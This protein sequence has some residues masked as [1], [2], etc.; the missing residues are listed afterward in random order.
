MSLGEFPDEILLAIF[1]HLSIDSLHQNVALVC[2]RFH[3]LSE[4]PIALKRL[5]LHIDK[6]GRANFNAKLL[7]LH[8]RTRVLDIQ[9][10]CCVNNKVMDSFGRIWWVPD[11]MPGHDDKAPSE[12]HK[13]QLV[14]PVQCCI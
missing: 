9:A 11:M 12:A 14:K 4:V 3:R 5:R 7:A 10:D 13:G 8:S 1:S 6:N 2:Q